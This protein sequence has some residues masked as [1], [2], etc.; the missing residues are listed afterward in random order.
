MV[1]L[2]S[3]GVLKPTHLTFEFGFVFLIL[4]SDPLHTG[5]PILILTLFANMPTELFLGFP[6]PTSPAF[7]HR[8][9]QSRRNAKIETTKANGRTIQRPWV[10]AVSEKNTSKENLMSLRIASLI[11]PPRG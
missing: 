11:R 5:N 6:C 7:F 1:K 2:E 8:N 3:C 10:F 9:I 4:L